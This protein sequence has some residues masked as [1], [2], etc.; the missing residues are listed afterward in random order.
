MTLARLHNPRFFSKTVDSWNSEI[1]GQKELCPMYKPP[2]RRLGQ[3]LF[4][5]LSPWDPCLYSFLFKFS[6][7]RTISHWNNLPRD[8]MESPALDTLKIWLDRVLG[9]LNWTVLFPRKVGA[10]DPWIFEVSSNPRFYDYK[11]FGVC[12]REL[13]LKNLSEKGYVEQPVLLLG[14]LWQLGVRVLVS[15]SP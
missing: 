6:V 9:H 15:V 8:A 2:L 13:I 1:C 5:G 14:E 3:L 7:M 4:P 10:D 11:Q 12:F